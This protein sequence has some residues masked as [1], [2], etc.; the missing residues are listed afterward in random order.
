MSQPD[1]LIMEEWDQQLYDMSALN[2][3]I[4]GY[5]LK[6]TKGL[7]QGSELAPALFNFYT[8]CILEELQLQEGTDV[9]IF[10]D[11]WVFKADSKD[12]LLELMNRANE[13]LK[14]FGMEFNTDEARFFRTA[15]QGFDVEPMEKE[16]ENEQTYKFLGIKWHFNNFNVWFKQE[17]AKFQL[18]KWRIKPGY[19]TI[20]LV[21]KFIVPKFRYYWGYLKKISRT[22]SYEYLQW[23]KKVLRTWLQKQLI[24]QNLPERMIEEI[25]FPVEHSFPCMA[26]V[27]ANANEYETRGLSTERCALL[28]RTIEMAKCV[29]HQ[30]K[31]LGIYQATNLLFNNRDIQTTISR[32]PDVEGKPYKRTLMVI[33][34]LYKAILGE[35]RISTALFRDQM[36]FAKKTRRKRTYKI[37]E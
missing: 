25:I 2:M 37:F 4:N 21:K 28:E 22:E 24:C 5:I 6:R 13:L 9:A 7:P 33:D 26:Q 23:F 14:T 35:N 1:A 10:A 16:K 19:E 15:D 12:K 29:V 27:L 8:T 18:P 32:N 30:R 31:K 3:D 34:I 36:N 17:E 11:N 20:K